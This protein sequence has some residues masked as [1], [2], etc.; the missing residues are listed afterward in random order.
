MLGYMSHDTSALVALAAVILLAGC[1]LAIIFRNASRRRQT[2]LNMSQFKTPRA[3][4]SE[5]PIPVTPFDMTRRYVSIYGV[6]RILRSR[7]LSSVFGCR[8]EWLLLQR[9]RENYEA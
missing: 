1:G 7:L 6:L 9:L 3:D 4:L 5:I 2:H 8:V